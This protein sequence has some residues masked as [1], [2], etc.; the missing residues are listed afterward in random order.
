MSTETELKTPASWTGV[1]AMAFGAFIFNTT[2]FIPIALLSDIGT[3]FAMPATDVGVMITVYAWIV[4]LASLPLMLLTRRFERKKLLLGLFALFTAGHI[5]S[6]FAWS[7]PVLMIS[8]IS[9]AVTHAIF[10]SIT[11]S[12]VV[13]IAP[14]GKKHKALSLL[15][16]GTTMAMV[17]GIPLGKLVSQYFGWRTSFALI[18]V[19]AVATGLVMLKA[20]PALPSQ[21]TGSLSSLP[22]LAKRKNL[23]ILFA[24]TTLIVTA[25]FT[26]YS[27]IEPFALKIAG[28]SPESTTLL[29]LCYGAAG[30]L[31]SFLFSRLFPKHPKTFFL[32]AISLIGLCML[33]LLPLSGSTAGLNLLA[34]F[35][36]TGIICVS[37]AMQAKILNF[38]ADATDVAMSIASGLYNVGIGGGALLGQILITRFGLTNIGFIG[39]TLALAAF[40]LA[41][42]LVKRPDFN[43]QEHS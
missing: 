9:I 3:S 42:A 34:L 22:V 24:F 32:A 13:R 28:F 25:H 10:W 40:L 5:V 36:G 35:W 20:L 39:A 6:V 23:M 38:A 7:F 12:L 43:T 2:E 19:C 4:A 17:M 29:L 8:R 1:M 27:Y 11:A 30:F 26:A 15:V 33:L 16:L 18:T 31:G 21:N 14:L 41:V 37:L